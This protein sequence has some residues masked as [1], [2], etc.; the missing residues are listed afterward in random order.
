MEGKVKIILGTE[1]EFE[2][3]PELLYADASVQSLIF[4]ALMQDKI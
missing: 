1:A 2:L 4:E 3:Y